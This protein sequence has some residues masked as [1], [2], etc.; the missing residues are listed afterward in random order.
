MTKNEA[1]KIVKDIYGKA[2]DNIQEG[3]G[4]IET[5]EVN[6]SVGDKETNAKAYKLNT[7]KIQKYFTDNAIDYIKVMF[8]D[9]PYGHKDGNYYI[10]TNEN[11]YSQNKK[12]FMNTIF[13]STDQAQ[14]DFEVK[15]YNDDMI[16]AISEKSSYFKLDEYIVLKKINNVWKIDMFD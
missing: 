2:Y 3:M 11:K 9:T 4:I 14:R 15:L 7:F 13:G 12:E 1:A 10:Y 5:D 16:V 8:T 6:V